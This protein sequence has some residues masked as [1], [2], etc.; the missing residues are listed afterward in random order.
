MHKQQEIILFLHSKLKSLT[1]IDDH[2]IIVHLGKSQPLTTSSM[3]R[4][5]VASADD[6]HSS[7]C[8]G[9]DGQ[10]FLYK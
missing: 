5:V 8:R 9:V 6:V 1:V 3:V 2:F 10:D 4:G 7:V